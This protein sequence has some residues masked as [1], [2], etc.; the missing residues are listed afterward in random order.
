M[1]GFRIGLVMLALVASC[2]GLPVSAQYAPQRT[3]WGDPDFRGTWSTQ[4]IADAEIPLQRPESLGNRLELNDEE[5]AARIASATASDTAYANEV[6][7]PGTQGLAG[8]LQSTPYGRRASLLVSPANGRLPPMTAEGERLYKAGRTSWNTDQ[9]VDWITDLDAYDRCISRGFPG[10]MLPYPTN[11]GFRM[12]QS[13]GFVVLQ[14][15]VLGTRIIPIGEGDRRPAAV[16]TWLGDSRGRWEGNTLVI[17]TANM[18]VGDG[19]SD[20]PFKRSGTPLNGR[21]WGTVPM[22]AQARAGERL[23]MTAP[24]RLA[25]Q[26]TYTDPEVFS[27]PWTIELEWTHDG[28]YRLYEF[29]CHE[30]NTG[31]RNMITASRA[32]HGRH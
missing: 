29:A 5:F 20:D 12:F 32:Q 22:S 10:A 11:D 1:G 7:F 24:D 31:I 14:L 26:V 23:T 30:G 21:D 4:N 27:A 25:Y 13:P 6:E 3:A 9:P 15:E 18:V 17:E 19:A 28:A 16:R 8:W 2:A